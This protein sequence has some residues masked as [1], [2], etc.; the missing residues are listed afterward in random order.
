MKDSAYVFENW[1]PYAQATHVIVGWKEDGSGGILATA[2]DE[3]TAHRY[4]KILRDDGY[5]RVK[6]RP[7]TE[8]VM[9][10]VREGLV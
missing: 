6:A 4:A 5:L 2:R 7:H 10:E 1:V 3:F 8:T 9:R